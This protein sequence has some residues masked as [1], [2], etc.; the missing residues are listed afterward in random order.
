M[1]LGT[2]IWHPPHISVAGEDDIIINLEKGREPGIEI[3]EC[4]QITSP[5]LVSDQ[6]VEFPGKR[7]H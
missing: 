5:G 3:I 2:R 6:N 1:N 7:V 4:T